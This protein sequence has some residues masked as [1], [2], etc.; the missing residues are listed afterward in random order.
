LS[1]V[2][3]VFFVI[4]SNKIS[5]TM[6]VVF[7]CLLAITSSAQK[8]AQAPTEEPIRKSFTFMDSEREYFVWLPK[9]FDQSKTY[10]PLVVVHGGGQINNGLFFWMIRPIRNIA[11]KLGLLAIVISPSFNLNDPVAQQYPA[12]VE[13]KFLKAVLKQ[14]HKTYN[15]YPRIL[16]TGY[17]R[18]GQFTHRFALWYPDLVEACAPFAAGAW[19]TPDGRLLTYSL[20]EIKNPKQFLTSLQTGEVVP[21][22]LNDPRVAEFAG[23]KPAPGSKRIPFLIMCGSLDKRFE[24]TKEFVKSLRQAGYKVETEW[25]RTPHVGRDT[26]KYQAEFDKYPQGAVEFFLRVTESK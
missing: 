7:F 1:E 13:G 17:S 19:T 12:G 5:I 20:G 24:I 4:V 8:L 11:D 26:E 10:W 15:L 22:S 25:P 23:D 18:G 6:V 16:L 21:Q 14:L 9:N 3:G 2:G